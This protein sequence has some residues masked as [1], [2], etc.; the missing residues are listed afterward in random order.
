MRTLLLAAL[1]LVGARCA[2]AQ[3]GLNLFWNNC[4]ADGGGIYRSF[5]CNTNS[6]SDVLVAS[7]VVPE[8]IPHF[9]AARVIVTVHMSGGVITP[10]WQV[11]AGQCRAN[12]ILPTF[13]PNQMPAS[14]ACP[15][16]WGS[17]V[18]LQV[19]AVQPDLN[20][21]GGAF[22]LNAGAAVA[23][24]SAFPVLQDGTDL[25]LCQFVIRHSKSTG[26]G[27]CEGC[28]SGAC[29]LFEVADLQQYPPYAIYRVTW[30]SVSRWAYYNSAGWSA[31]DVWIPCAVP[32]LNRTWGAIK[33]LYR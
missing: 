18:P 12:A 32:A 28:S 29:F 5:A 8:A 25:L 4:H 14:E 23:E 6:G 30:P 2:H 21:Y 9:A 7:V 33:S 11:A 24:E 3:S 13:D 27:A 20:G 22:R 17:I 10:W 16:I 15:T 1:L 26:T 19:F 31:Q